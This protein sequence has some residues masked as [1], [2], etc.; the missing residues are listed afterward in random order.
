[1]YYIQAASSITHQAT[2][3]NPGFFSSIQKIE[4]DAELVQPAYREFIDPRSLRRMSK[5]LRMSLSC[6]KDC[7]IQ[8]NIDQP[9]A[10]IIGTGL[11]ALNDTEKFL[12]NFITASE[13]A[14]IPPT[15]FIQST[16]NTMA[17]QLSLLLKNHNYNMTHTQNSLSF[18]LALQDGLLSLDEGLPNV[19]VGAAD[20]HIDFLDL[21]AQKLN[22]ESLQLTSGSSF[23]ALSKEE[24][25][26]PLAQITD[27]QTI[28]LFSSFNICVH[29][30][31]DKNSLSP[32]EIDLVLF[33]S[34]VDTQTFEIQ[35]IFKKSKKYNYTDYSGV[36]MTNAAFAY[37]WAADEI[38]HGNYKRVLVCNNLNP[39]NLGLTLIENCE[40]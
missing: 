32:T 6:A 26:N 1:M 15:S 23:F 21:L 13:D 40:T 34:L 18:E 36:Y 4:S 20:E 29:T 19:L 30:F 39:E 12:K 10:L 7:L 3:Q 14:L 35:T 28:G 33:S 27:V 8:A 5:I 17:G 31:L 2:F 11:G 9:G 25:T 22:F 24:N 16:H 37:H 38:S